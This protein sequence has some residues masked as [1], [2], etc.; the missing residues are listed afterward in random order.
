MAAVF[1]LENYLQTAS[2]DFLTATL[3]PQNG[4]RRTSPMGNGL[5][6]ESMTLTGV[7]TDAAIRAAVQTI[8]EIA[9]AVREFWDDPVQD[10]TYWWREES[11]GETS[12]SKRALIHSITMQPVTR[13]NFGAILGKTGA[14]YDLVIVRESI[15]EVFS[16]AS[17]SSNGVSALG[18][19]VSFAAIPGSYSARIALLSFTGANG[20][21]TL[22]R[23]WAGIRPTYRGSSDFVALWELEAGTIN[24]T[25]GSSFATDTD[26]SPQASANNITEYPVDTASNWVAKVTIDDITATTNYQHFAGQYLVLL[27][28]KLSAGNEVVLQMRTGYSQNATF[29][30]GELKPVTATSYRFCEMGTVGIPPMGYR[31]EFH[32]SAGDDVTLKNYQIQ[33][34]AYRTG[35]AVNLTVDCLVLIPIPH[36][37]YSEG[38]AI[39]YTDASSQTSTYHRTTAD[40][41]AIALYYDTGSN[42]TTNLIYTLDPADWVMPIGGG[43]LVFAA[44]RTASQVVSDAAN[45]G[46][47]L[48]YRHRVHA[49]DV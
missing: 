24:T 47:A 27:R 41:R 11:S 37:T 49:E 20:G 17:S 8:T 42:P 34:W 44:E 19:L 16:Q 30:P 40:G 6:S 32:P 48:I 7:G 39:V 25:A 22:D 29:A 1:R 35:A 12:N 43:V 26:A 31:Y 5:V 21:G 10:N 38:S 9:D 45:I 28:Y 3:K 15:F 13:G 33:I 23:L 18:G 2:Y 4:T 46:W 36:F 14:F